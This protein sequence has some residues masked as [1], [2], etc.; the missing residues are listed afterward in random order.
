MVT[1][2]RWLALLQAYEQ[3]IGDGPLA[4]LVE[5]NR[6]RYSHCLLVVMRV[7]PLFVKVVRR[8]PTAA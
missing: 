7:T 6:F 5:V 8:L 2:V 4:E 1:A 3:P